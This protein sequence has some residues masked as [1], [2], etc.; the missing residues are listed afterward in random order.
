MRTITNPVTVTVI[1][2]QDELIDGQWLNVKLLSDRLKHMEMSKG[3]GYKE[4]RSKFYNSI[5]AEKYN[6]TNTSYGFDCI[7]IINPM[8][9]KASLELS[10]VVKE[11]E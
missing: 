1:T 6:I 11:R 5:H 4:L 8:Q 3:M 2:Y 9:E 7:D 10:F